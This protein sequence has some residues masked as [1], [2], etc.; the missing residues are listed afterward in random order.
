MSPEVIDWLTW[1]V[2]QQTVQVG[3]PDARAQALMAWR[4]L[5]E[6][7]AMGAQSPDSP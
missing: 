2:G 5:D 1:L 6:L 3:A 7:A 4:A